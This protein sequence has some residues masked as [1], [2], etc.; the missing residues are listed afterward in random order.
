MRTIMAVNNLSELKEAELI[1][2]II[3][4]QV[5]DSVVDIVHRSNS[6]E[7]M[8]DRMVEESAIIEETG[9]PKELPKRVKGVRM[10]PDE[11]VGKAS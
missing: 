8:L 2:E 6:D 3:H 4:Q 1:R 11:T 5:P 10:I 9:V 7:V